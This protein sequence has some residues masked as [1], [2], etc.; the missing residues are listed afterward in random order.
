MT[1]TRKQWKA[2]ARRALQ[3][4]YTIAIFGMLATLGVN[5]AGSGFA[6]VLFPG[7]TVP[8]IIAGEAFLF[9]FSLILNIFMAGYS[10]L[11]L[12]L[13]REQNARMGDLLYFF[14]NQPDRVIIAGFFMVLLQLIATVPSIIYTYTSDM[15]NTMEA[16]ME[17][18]SSFLLLTV[19]SAILQL[20]FTMPFSMAYYLLADHNEM[21]GMEAL[22]KSASMMKGHLG[23]FLLLQISFFPMIFVSALLLYI[24]LLW[25]IPYMEMAN[26]EF[27]RDLSGE[28]RMSY[29]TEPSDPSCTDGNWEGY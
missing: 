3:G 4:N 18:L 21:G 16:Q 19:V 7:S 29:E 6:D 1:K 27:Y 25:V 22:K 15:G 12:N 11:L 8:A 10:Y 26:V 28:F 9:I 14:R 20:L 23:Q 13:S 17:W 5:L 24:P 2:G